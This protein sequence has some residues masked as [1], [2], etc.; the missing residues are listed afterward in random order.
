MRICKLQSHIARG[1][2]QNSGSHPPKEIVGPLTCLSR[3]PRLSF[4]SLVCF[5]LALVFGELEDLGGLT[6]ADD[7]G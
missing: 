1:A 4:D 3:M 7:L 2:N 5:V 6:P